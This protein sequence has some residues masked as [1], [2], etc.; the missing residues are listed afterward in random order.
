MIPISEYKRVFCPYCKDKDFKDCEIRICI[1]E[2]PRCQYYELDK[3]K[4]K[5]DYGEPIWR[6][7]KKKL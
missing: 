1:D 3:D 6:L 4:L 2:K 7:I 5:E